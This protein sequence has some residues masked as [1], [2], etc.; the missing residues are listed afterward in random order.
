MGVTGAAQKGKRWDNHKLFESIRNRRTAT[1]TDSI[2]Y[3]QE[4][5]V[6]TYGFRSDTVKPDRNGIYHAV[7]L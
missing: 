5:L 3:T 1:Y 6:E 4:R 2:Y 7:S